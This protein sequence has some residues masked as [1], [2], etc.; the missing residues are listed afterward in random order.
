MLLF[1][2][3]K[4]STGEAAAVLTVFGGSIFL[5]IFFYFLFILVPTVIAIYRRH[6]Q[7]LPI[8]IINLLLGWTGIVWV[9]CLAWSCWNFGGAKAKKT[10]RRKTK[11]TGTQRFR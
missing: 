11:K 3:E 5:A 4:M 8:F 7:T 2:Q 10:G 1:A 6:P 9:V